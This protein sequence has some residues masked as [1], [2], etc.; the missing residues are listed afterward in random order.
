VTIETTVSISNYSAVYR[1]KILFLV[2]TC[3]YLSGKLL[4]TNESVA[5]K[6][7]NG[8][9]KSEFRLTGH[10]PAIQPKG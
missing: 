10:A 5:Y 2:R 4:P 7:A 3:L 1:A 9:N 6:V 8:A